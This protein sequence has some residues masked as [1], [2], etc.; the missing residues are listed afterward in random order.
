[1]EEK[2]YQCGRPSVH[3]EPEKQNPQTRHKFVNSRKRKQRIFS[4]E[5]QVQ[6]TEHP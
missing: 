3:Y 4:L 5:A 1:M 6:R 2:K